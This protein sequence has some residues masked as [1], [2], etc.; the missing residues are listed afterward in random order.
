MMAVVISF[1]GAI[2]IATRGEITSFGDVSR[3]GIFLAGSS[4]LIWAVYWLINAKDGLDP[5]VTLFTGFC[6]GL[7]YTVLFCMFA[8]GLVL[9]EGCV[10]LPLSYIGLFEMSITFVCWLT[11]LQLTSSVARIG[12]LIYVTPFCSLLLLN[13][14]VG[15][16][17]YLATFVGLFLIVG[18]TLFQGWQN[19]GVRVVAR[20]RY[21]DK[22]RKYV[23]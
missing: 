17:I 1:V 7:L 10:W 3:L 4:T 18:T 22:S 9:P 20:F 13:L 23:I 11:A 2:I 6:F 5:V 16:K 21:F 19:R 8:G 14:V 12:N 15:E